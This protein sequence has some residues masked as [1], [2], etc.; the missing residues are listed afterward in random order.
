MVMAEKPLGMA[1]ELLG[2]DLLS[3]KAS[4]KSNVAKEA[5]KRGG[6][7]LAPLFSDLLQFRA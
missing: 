5:S 3:F 1:E 6:Q 2:W 7:I 4:S